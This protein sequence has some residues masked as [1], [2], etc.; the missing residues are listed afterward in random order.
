M[1]VLIGLGLYDEKDVS[2]KG[3][4][5]AKSSSK[6]Y[7]ETYTSIWKGSLKNL[8]KIVGK[9]IKVLKRKDLEENF[10][11]ILEEAKNKKIAIFVPGDPLIATT[12]SALI[13]EAKKRKINTK[14]VHS[15]S[16]NSAIAE[17]GLHIYKF[18]RIVTIPLK[19]KI[20]L[21]KSVYDAI[22]ENKEKDLHTLCLLDFDAEKR[23]FLSVKDAINI[24]I[25]MEKKF[26]KKV[27]DEK[28]K[29]IVLSC[30]GGKG[31]KIVYEEIKKFLRKSLSFQLA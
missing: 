18:G 22:K 8:E 10:E 1:I 24:L 14:I 2:L 11:K 7:V 12:H 17:C 19:E 16:I 29:V 28:E 27:I 31:Q 13:L 3:I 9:K 21:P 25:E 5:E 15:S 6:I 30:I 4:E 20:E 26:G 23:K